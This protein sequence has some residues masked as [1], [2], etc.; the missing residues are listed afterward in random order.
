MSAG[1]IL[2]RFDADFKSSVDRSSEQWRHYCEARHYAIL[3]Y[4][5]INS[6]FGPTAVSVA[7]TRFR[8]RLISIEAKRGAAAKSKLDRDVRLILQQEFK[9]DLGTAVA[10]AK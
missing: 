2:Y 8:E 10:V 1:A 6:S 7:L 9:V 5:D 3:V 4:R